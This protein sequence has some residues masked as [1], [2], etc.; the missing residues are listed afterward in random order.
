MAKKAKNSSKAQPL[1]IMSFVYLLLAFLLTACFL[2]FML[3]LRPLLTHPDFSEKVGTFT[4]FLMIF[5]ILLTGVSAMLVF[6]L[7]D[8]K[9]VI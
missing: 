3:I 4:F 6:I 7:L 1:K 5:L 2:V 8:K 9:K